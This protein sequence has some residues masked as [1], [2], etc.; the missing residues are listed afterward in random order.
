[1]T[2]L[3]TGGAGYIGSHMALQLVDAGERVVVLDNLS[4]GL[5]WAVP[6]D[7][8]FVRGDVGDQGLVRRLLDGHGIDAII[9]FAGSVVVPDSVA[10]PLGYYLNNTVNSRA[11]I[12]AAVK[13]GVRHFIFSSTAAVYGMTGD[14]PVTEEAPLA[15]MS[16]YGSSKRMTEIM[17]ADAAR[18]HDL[19]YVALR[20]F[21]VAGADPQ[22]RAGQATPRATHL[23]KVA[24]ETALGKRSHMEVFGTDYPT[25]D[26]T[27]VRDY[28]HVTDLAGAHM[29]ALAHLR[30][31]GDSDIF[32]CGYG[33]GCSV[34]EVIEAVRRAAGRD[35]DVRMAPRRPGDPAIVVADT[36]RI[37][38]RLGWTPR[39]DSLDGIVRTALR[40]EER[41]A[42]MVEEPAGAA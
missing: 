41:L 38:A 11:L 27:C 40:W 8:A 19:R 5:A 42:T 4:T 30:A 21:N 34:L 2:V 33:R 22:G 16:P 13:S 12:E 7:A 23:V 20:Y 31:G 25:P 18:A 14:R 24:C 6:Q 37:R 26:G 17:L 15:P 39:H 35:F 29:A 1:M 32:N 10:D 28:I 9:H 3:V 36:R